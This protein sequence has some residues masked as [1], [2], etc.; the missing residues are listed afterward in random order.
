MASRGFE[1]SA[2]RWLRA[3]PV[4]WRE[5]R[6]E[7]MLGV[8]EELADD[9]ARRVDLRTGFGLVRGG[10]ATR[11]RY[12]PP[13]Y[14]VVLYRLG[15]VRLPERFRW[16]A[17]Q[18][19]KGR[20]FPLRE[21]SP[22]LG[23]LVLLLVLPFMWGPGRASLT[24]ASFVP[25]LALT[26]LYF[27]P[28]MGRR[29]RRLA[30]E[31]AFVVRVPPLARVDDEPEQPLTPE[32][33]RPRRRV[34]A[35]PG[36]GRAAVVLTLGAVV[37]PAAAA[38][39]PKRIANIPCAVEGVGVCWESVVV[40]RAPGVGVALVVWVALAVVAGVALARRA[41][42]R[43]H[44]AQLPAQPHRELVASRVPWGSVTAAGVIVAV[45]VAEATGVLAQLFAAPLAVGCVVGL[46][47]VI[48][49]RAGLADRGDARDWAVLD[50]WR[51]AVSRSGVVLTDPPIREVIVP[52]APP[53]LAG[54]AE[55]PLPS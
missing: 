5:R 41:T 55:G 28:P 52:A 38:L 39:A 36:L 48:G 22:V 42:R 25:V 31:R 43:V 21:A 9:G 1:R 26:G 8:L 33:L 11:W 49:Q 19:I 35:Q 27:M 2:R 34:A 6:G 44:Q 47:L 10:W 45:G 54:S 46:G 17:A 16:W 7:E 51:A 24:W 12:R 30:W 40:P 4:W 23:L 20:F 53:E 50:A 37:L 13:W 15:I 29:V 14:R 3:Y 32:R 18:D